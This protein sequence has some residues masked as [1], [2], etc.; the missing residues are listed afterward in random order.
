[1]LFYLQGPYFDVSI[2]HN[3]FGGAKTWK[4]RAILVETLYNPMILSLHAKINA[5]VLFKSICISKTD[6]CLEDWIALQIYVPTF[7]RRSSWTFSRFLS[8]TIHWV[9]GSPGISYHKLPAGIC[10]VHSTCNLIMKRLASCVINLMEEIMAHLSCIM[11]HCRF[12][13]RLREKNDL[14]TG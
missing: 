9:I 6:P 14:H 4:E 1:M 2:P 13:N 8:M 7:R 11:K 12:T 10:H 3:S 5:L